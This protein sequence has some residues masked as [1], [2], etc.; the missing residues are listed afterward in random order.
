MT[1]YAEY[2]HTQTLYVA[3]NV[4]RETY[5][6]QTKKGF[7]FIFALQVTDITRYVGLTHPCAFT[8]FNFILI[9]QVAILLC[10]SEKY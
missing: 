8:Y 2:A 3:N 6:S 4:Y 5:T 1:I 10:I 7:L 9:W